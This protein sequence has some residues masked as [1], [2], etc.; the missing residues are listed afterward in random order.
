MK[1]VMLILCLLACFSLLLCSCGD[2]K[3][4]AGTGEPTSASATSEPEQPT[5]ARVTETET[6][7]VTEPDG[8]DH[9][10]L[11]TDNRDAGWTP[12]Y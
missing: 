11:S 3:N 10:A 6:P 2:G 9:P 7:E 4:D 12:E 5:S 8:T 1:K